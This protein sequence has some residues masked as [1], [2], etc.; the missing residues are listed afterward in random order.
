MINSQLF[1]VAM[2]NGCHYFHIGSSSLMTK[3]DYCQLY[4]VW[5]TGNPVVG[6]LPVVGR[7]WS[8]EKTEKRE[9]DGV[10]LTNEEINE[11]IT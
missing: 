2:L 3:G 5:R 11:F 8:E 10:Y 7:R 4:L 1:R 6:V 9:E